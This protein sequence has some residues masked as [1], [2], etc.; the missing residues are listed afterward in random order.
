M[1]TVQ[2]AQEL[3]ESVNAL[4]WTLKLGTVSESVYWNSYKRDLPTLSHEKVSAVLAAAGFP[5]SYVHVLHPALTV[6]ECR[7]SVIRDY[8]TRNY[9]FIE[10]DYE[11]RFDCAEEYCGEEE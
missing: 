9:V 3:A 4:A 7:L 8:L 11:P 6:L 5:D 2:A 10:S 1:T